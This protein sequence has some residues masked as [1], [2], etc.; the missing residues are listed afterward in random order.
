MVRDQVSMV[1][2]RRG[3]ADF[4]RKSSEFSGGVGFC[5]VS[6]KNKPSPINLRVERKKFCENIHAVV[7]GIQC[8]AC[9]KRD[10]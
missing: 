7:L 6:V 3:R 10:E 4:L 8:V 2:V 1:G 5:V 9:W